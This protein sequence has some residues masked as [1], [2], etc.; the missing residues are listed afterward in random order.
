LKDRNYGNRFEVGAMGGSRGKLQ[1]GKNISI[2]NPM[3]VTEL[4]WHFMPEPLPQPVQFPVPAKPRWAVD[5]GRSRGG[6]RGES[7]GTLTLMARAD[8]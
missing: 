3:A 6:S 2:L 4:G 1:P 5:P 8:R 7:N